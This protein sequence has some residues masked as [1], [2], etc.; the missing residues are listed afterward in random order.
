MGNLEQFTPKESPTA[1]AIFDWWKKHGDAEAPRGYLGASQIGHACSRY[2]W[3]SFR[4]LGRENFPGRLYRLFQT[5]QLEEERVATDLRAF[6]CEVFLDDPETGEQFAISDCDGHF[7]GHLDGCVLGVIE[8]PK[9]WHVLEVKT[10]NAKSFGKL[11]REGVQQ[12]KPLH[13]AQMQVYMRKTG[14]DRALYF[15]VCKDTDDIYV[16]RVRMDAAFADGMLARAQRI[17]DAAEPPLKADDS[18]GSTACQYC[19][20]QN[21]CHGNPAG[22]AVPA[23]VSCRSCGFSKTKPGGKWWCEFKNKFL[24]EIDQW[25]ACDAHLWSPGIVPFAEAVDTG[26]NA[27]GTRW[28][29][30]LN[31]SDN[32]TW[33]NG[34]DPSD[35]QFSSLELTKTP[36]AALHG[37]TGERL[38][39]LKVAMKGKVV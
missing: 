20:M 3:Y 31:V 17:I 30:Y 23:P 19:C 8:A 18:A 4:W 11:Q 37:K 33:R 21:L 12:S 22:F 15:A 38:M 24:S 10:H 16:E 29:E 36:Q 1:T 28:V 5:G 2:L 34:P 26:L 25:K 6:G 35:G 7:S 13:Y 14:M 39:A 27:N 32:S 9:A